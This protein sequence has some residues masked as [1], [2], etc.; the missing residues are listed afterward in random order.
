MGRNMITVSFRSTGGGGLRVKFCVSIC[1]AAGSHMPSV[2]SALLMKV[3]IGCCS[4][5]QYLAVTRSDRR[6]L[7]F[8]REE[9]CSV[10]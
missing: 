5:T 7:Q 10:Y 2:R 9:L 8:I 6:R 4:H 3:G 1:L